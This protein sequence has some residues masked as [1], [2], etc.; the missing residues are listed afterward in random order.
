MGNM[1]IIIS[2]IVSRLDRFLKSDRLNVGA[3]KFTSFH[4]VVSL[5]ERRFVCVASLLL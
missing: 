3:K 2:I 1:I 5:C 4:V